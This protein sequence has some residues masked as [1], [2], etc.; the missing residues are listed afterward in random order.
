MDSRERKQGKELGKRETKAPPLSNYA[1]TGKCTSSRSGKEVADLEE[2][3]ETAD[4]L[5]GGDNDKFEPA[6]FSSQRA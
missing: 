6:T 3:L 2:M 5:A 4:P 1:A